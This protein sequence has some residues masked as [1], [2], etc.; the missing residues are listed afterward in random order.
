VVVAEEREDGSDSTRSGAT[1]QTTMC[2]TSTHR[3]EITLL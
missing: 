3:G 1:V 2:P